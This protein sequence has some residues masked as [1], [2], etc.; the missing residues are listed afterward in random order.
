MEQRAV[1]AKVVGSKPTGAAKQETDDMAKMSFLAHVE[2]A[3]QER[4]KY[5]EEAESAKEALAEACRVL[6]NHRVR[7]SDSNLTEWRKRFRNER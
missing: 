6:D 4:I 1:N 3:A 7:S 2:R 5:R